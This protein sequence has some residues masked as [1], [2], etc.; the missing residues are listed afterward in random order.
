[1]NTAATKQSFYVAPFSFDGEFFGLAEWDIAKLSARWLGFCRDLL[2]SHGPIFTTTLPGPLHRIGLRFTSAQGAA[3]A[4]FSFDGIPV[5]SSALLRGE[6]PEAERE[7]LTMFLQS[8][9]QLDIVRTSQ[10]DSEPFAEVLGIRERPLHAVITFG[11]GADAD[12][13]PELGTHLAAA[14]LYDERA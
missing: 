10:N 1:M 2:S 7:L 11:G 13:I 8:A 6:A 12:T 3:L 5:A 4:T 14:F 9:R